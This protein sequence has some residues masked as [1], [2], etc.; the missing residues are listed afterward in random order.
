MPARGVL[1]AL[2]ATLALAAPVSAQPLTTDL[3]DGTHPDPACDGVLR[4]HL[5]GDLAPIVRPTD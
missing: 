4:V 2:A 3:P 5:R 1:L